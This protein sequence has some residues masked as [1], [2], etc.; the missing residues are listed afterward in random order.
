MNSKSHTAT[1]KLGDTSTSLIANRTVL[2]FVSS[3][4]SDLQA[5]RDELVANV[6]PRIR[7]YCRD[8]SVVFT[9]VDLRW[10]ITRQ[11]AN[12][13]EI[14]S[15]CF[16]EIERCEPFFIGII[17]DRYGWVPDH[18]KDI[19]DPFRKQHAWLNS[20]NNT[21]VTEMESFMVY[22]TE[23]QVPTS[24]CSTPSTS[25]ALP[26]VKLKLRATMNHSMKS[27]SW[28]L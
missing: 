26:L 5:E 23:T 14:L 28:K 8:R 15:R 25:L 7:S 2:L 17:G 18:E 6:F 3:T 1:D 13:K 12:D 16:H 19:L 4:F 20:L 11:Q 27:R 21:S 24:H 22:S 10:G 9:E